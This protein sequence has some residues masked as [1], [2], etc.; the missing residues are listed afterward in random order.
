M[1]SEPLRPWSG[2][3]VVDR[4]AESMSLIHRLRERTFHQILATTKGVLDPPIF[5]ILGRLT[6]EGPMRSGALAQ[7]VCSDPSTV[8]RQVAALVERGLVRREA[9]PADGRISVLV[10]TDKGR[11]VVVAAKKRRNAMLSMVM[12]DWSDADRAEFARLLASFADGFQQCRHD[13]IAPVRQSGWA[14]LA[15]GENE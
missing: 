15:N 3:P 9:D 13:F 1:Q 2:D 10:V 8:S 6:T 5:M 12:A 7:A 14:T 4:I 11:E